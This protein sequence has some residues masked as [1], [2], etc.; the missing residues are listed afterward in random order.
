MQIHEEAQF[1]YCTGIA[2]GVVYGGARVGDQL[3]ELERNGCDLLVATPE[4]LMDLIERGRISLAGIGFLIL[5]EADHARRGHDQLRRI[6]GGRY[7]QG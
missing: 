7:A 1:V 2:A 4:R 5:D 3:R 6:V